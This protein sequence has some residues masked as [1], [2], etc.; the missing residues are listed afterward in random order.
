LDN[1]KIY[2]E[3]YNNDFLIL[4]ETDGISNIIPQ[5]GQALFDARFKFT[6]EV[7]CTET[8]V[9]LKLNEKYSSKEIYEIINISEIAFENRHLNKKTVEIIY[10][11]P[12]CFETG[13]DW[14]LIEDNCRTTVEKYINEILKIEFTLSMYGFLPGFL[15]MTGLPPHLHCKRKSTPTTI[16]RPNSLAI[17][18][19]YLGLYSIPSP[20]GWNLIGS[21]A[22]TACNIPCVPPN[23]LKVGDKIKLERITQDELS[24]LQ[25]SD[26]DLISYNAKS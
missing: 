22:F 4:K 6:D 12:V 23:L 1:H 3:N 18:A 5:I 26:H 11:L 25:S 16:I 13:T 15:Y 7:I 8:E 19:Q 20:A 9:C 10:N 17:G 14:N 21:S 2:I 24:I